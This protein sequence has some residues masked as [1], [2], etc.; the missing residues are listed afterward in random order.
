[1]RG[2]V[3][4]LHRPVDKGQETIRVLEERLARGG[5]LNMTLIANEELSAERAFEDLDLL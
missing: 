5:Q 2:E 4:T 3:G 1:V